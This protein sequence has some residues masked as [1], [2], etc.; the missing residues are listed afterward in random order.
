M[1]LKD[2]LFEA[3]TPS[4]VITAYHGGTGF[5]GGFNMD[6]S[7]SGEGY[8]MLGPGMYFIT[9]EFMAQTYAKKYAKRNPTV[10]T[11]KLRMDNIYNNRNVPSPQMEQSMNNIARELG[12]QTFT[13]VP[14]QYDELKNGRGFIGSVVKLVGH[15]KA[16]A[17]F[18]KHGINGAAENLDTDIWEICIF[19]PSCI[20]IV[21][22]T[23][24]EHEEV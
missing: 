15:T 7:G 23:P 11:C 2:I 4:G 10:Y 5:D 17:L 9:S 3:E 13:E 6:F 21:D 19:N 16:R 22:R 14:R 1:R 12:Y 8:R 24:L 18:V 20:Q